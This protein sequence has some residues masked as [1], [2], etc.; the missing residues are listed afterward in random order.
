MLIF[1]KKGEIE[2]TRLQATQMLKYSMDLSVS[3]LDSQVIETV[4]TGGIAIM[5]LKHPEF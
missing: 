2:I 3:K 4:Y 1:E 5:S